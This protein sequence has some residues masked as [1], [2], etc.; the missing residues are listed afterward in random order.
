[1]C[2]L[3]HIYYIEKEVIEMD[4][5]T[6]TTLISTL[7]FPIAACVALFWY[8]IKQ[9]EHHKEE[10]EKLR[11]SIDGNTMILTKLYERLGSGGHNG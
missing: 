7:G 10:T 6:V 9:D 4:V 5:S 11:E 8:M 1:M 3:L 2:K